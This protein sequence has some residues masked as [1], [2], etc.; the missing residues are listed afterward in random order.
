VEASQNAA[1]IGGQSDL[2][3]GGSPDGDGM[4]KDMDEE[5]LGGGGKVPSGNQ[6]GLSFTKNLFNR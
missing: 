4:I 5:E 3:G 2:L 1:H 6:F